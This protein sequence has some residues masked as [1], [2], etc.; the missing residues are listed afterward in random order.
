MKKIQLL[1]VG[2]L[3]SNI[4]F[5]YADAIDLENDIAKI[6]EDIIVIQ[7]KLYR[8]RSDTTAPQETVSSVQMR[9]GE[10]DQMIRDMNGKVEN[11]EYRLMNLEKKLE[12][13]DKD[14]DLRFEQFKRQTTEEQTE[15][16]KKTSK[17]NNSKLKNVKNAKD[18]YELALKD[19]KNNKLVKAKD[20]LSEFIEK[21]K[22]NPLAANAQYWLGEVYYKQQNFTQAAV[23]FRDGYKKY[24][25]GAKGPDCLLKLGLSMKAMNKTNEACTAFVNIPKIFGKADPTITERAKSEAEAL[26]CK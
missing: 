22:D 9:M 7:R 15:P 3:L 13:F 2:L 10:Y 16:K 18:L 14:I 6:K 17:K 19:L 23:A 8:E 11:I 24:P 5:A 1:C 20:E 12:T 25:E 26:K 21:Y 4:S